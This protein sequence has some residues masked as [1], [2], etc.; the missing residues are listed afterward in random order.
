MGT[1]SRDCWLATVRPANETYAELTLGGITLYSS[2][3][4]CLKSRI[5]E[6]SAA[7]HAETKDQLLLIR[8]VLRSQIRAR[9]DFDL[10]DRAFGAVLGRMLKVGDLKILL[11]LS[12]NLKLIRVLFQSANADRVNNILGD[13]RQ[14]LDQKGVISTSEVQLRHFKGRGGYYMAQQICGALVYQGRAVA[15]DRDLFLIPFEV[16]RAVC[17]DS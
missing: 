1:K 4:G 9:L 7:I 12:S 13:A 8:Q 2:S 10:S 5:D 6:V 16:Y 15:S 11:S 17:S 3:L 14:M